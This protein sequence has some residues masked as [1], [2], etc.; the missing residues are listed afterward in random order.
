MSAGEVP[1]CR[2]PEAHGSQ[3]VGPE[4]QRR[5]LGDQ[6]RAVGPDLPL[7][8]GRHGGARR[9]LQADLAAQEVG[10]AVGQEVLDRTERLV[11][12]VV[13]ALRQASPAEQSGV[14]PVV[15]LDEGADAVVAVEAEPRGGAL[16]PRPDAELLAGELDVTDQQVPGVLARRPG[17]VVSDRLPE[18][19]LERSAQ[20]GDAEP[21]RRGAVVLANRRRRLRLGRPEEDAHAGRLADDGDPLEFEPTVRTLRHLL[22]RHGVPHHRSDLEV[23]GRGDDRSAEVLADSR[24]RD[25]RHGHGEDRGDRDHRNSRSPSELHSCPLADVGWAGRTWQVTQS[26]PTR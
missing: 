25:C 11:T 15:R 17:E 13:E 24:F 12:G 10:V 16:P 26:L 23:V 22:P 2:A 18:A 9:R 6:P 7:V 20:P 8:A 4:V 14:E 5:S 19:E 21:P 1:V 3:E